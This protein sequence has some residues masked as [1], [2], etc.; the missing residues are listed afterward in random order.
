MVGPSR[1]ARGGIASVI[2]GYCEVGFPQGTVVTCVSTHADG[3]PAAKVAIGSKGIATAIRALRTTDVVHVHASSGAS[4][5]R[6]SFI[7]QAARAAGVSTVIHIHGSAFDVFADGPVRPIVRAVLARADAVVALSPQWMDSL[8]SIAPQANVVVIPN[9]V[10]IPPKSVKAESG[11][12][13][14]VGRVGQRKGT[15]EIIRAVEALADPDV[16]VVFAGDGAV[17]AF[18]AE[19]RE[20]GVDGQIEFLGWIELID[21]TPSCGKRPGFCCRPTPRVSLWLSWRRWPMDY[22]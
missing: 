8:L 17:D 14:C 6:K 20:R 1:T 11:P 7:L 10:N 19:A 12:L 15:T 16:R 5:A 9:G 3:S 21:A 13:V 18:Q 4:F 2:S 22:P